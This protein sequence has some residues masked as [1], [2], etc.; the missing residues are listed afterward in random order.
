MTATGGPLESVSFGGRELPV[1][2]DSDPTVVM[3]GIEIA[4]E[5][6][7]NFTH[8]ELRTPVPWSI[9]SVKLT[10]DI[11]NGDHEYLVD[12]QKKGGGEVVITY[13]GG[14]N[15]IGNGNITGT[16]EANPATASVTLSAGGSGMIKKL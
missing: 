13:A 4:H 10:F 6:N 16:I 1:T 2:V 15:Y 7:G 5:M 12:F 3:G 9:S 11:E 8:R 14:I